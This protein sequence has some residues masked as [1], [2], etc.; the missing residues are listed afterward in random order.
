VRGR[1]GAAPCGSGKRG[2]E[3]QENEE[4]EREDDKISKWWQENSSLHEQ[5]AITK[6]RYIILGRNRF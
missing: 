1:R 4:K 5:R 2:S 6:N 3:R